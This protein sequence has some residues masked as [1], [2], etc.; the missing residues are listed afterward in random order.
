MPVMQLS[1]DFVDVTYIMV[2]NNKS[3]AVYVAIL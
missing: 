1:I 3:I 2:N